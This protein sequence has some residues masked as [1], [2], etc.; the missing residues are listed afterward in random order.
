MT[1]V[2]RRNQLRQANRLRY[3]SLRENQAR[4][5]E[6]LGLFGRQEI[7][8]SVGAELAKGATSVAFPPAPEPMAWE[9]FDDGAAGLRDEVIPPSTFSAG[10]AAKQ[11]RKRIRP[12]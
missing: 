2:R 5:L 11:R 4:F 12:G 7:Q 3:A 8:W 6:R 10:S 9:E 1:N